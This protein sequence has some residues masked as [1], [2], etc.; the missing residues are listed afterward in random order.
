MGLHH[1][2]EIAL[3]Q[4]VLPCLIV[5]P[6][7]PSSSRVTLPPAPAGR[8]RRGQLRVA[9]IPGRGPCLSADTI[10]LVF[11]AKAETLGLAQPT[12]SQI[13][14]Y[15]SRHPILR[16][17]LRSRLPPSAPPW[18]ARCNRHKAAAIHCGRFLRLQT[19]CLSS[20]ATTLLF[21]WACSGMN[22]ANQAAEFLGRVISY[23]GFQMFHAAPL[24]WGN[25]TDRTGG[26]QRAL[27]KS[28]DD[29]LPPATELAGLLFQ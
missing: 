9:A 11:M 24:A 21:H 18:I 28:L 5:W 16:D 10:P 25:G 3:T 23:C 26:W 20:A 12:E 4:T 2:L 1:I 6:Q 13:I 15:I 14:S 7:S 29:N 19:I 8:L 17:R 27:P 22:T